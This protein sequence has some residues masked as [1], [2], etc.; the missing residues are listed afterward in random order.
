MVKLLTSLAAGTLFKT[1]VWKRHISTPNDHSEMCTSNL[2]FLADYLD[3]KEGKATHAPK[4][5]PGSK[6][7]LT[8]LH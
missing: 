1:R 4:K 3:A 6:R 8:S 5:A 7:H 2:K